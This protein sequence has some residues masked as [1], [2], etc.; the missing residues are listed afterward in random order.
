MKYIDD[1]LYLAGWI[2]MIAV[3]FSFDW[4]AGLIA[5]SAGCWV[6]A[7][8]IAKSGMRSSIRD[9]PRGSDQ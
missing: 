3:A 9:K 4:R 5:M 7:V 8:I 6:T 2:F 1:I